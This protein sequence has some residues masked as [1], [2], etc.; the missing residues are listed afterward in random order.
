M[1]NSGVASYNVVL[2]GDG[3]VGKSALAI[4]LSQHEFVTEYN[5]VCGALPFLFLSFS[6]ALSLS[7]HHNLGNTQTI[8]DCFRHQMRVDDGNVLLEVMDTAGQ[9][10]YSSLRDQ[11][12]AKGQG[13]MV[14]YSVVA[15][16][17]FDSVV[18]Y[19]AHI[20]RAKQD[21]AFPLVLVGNKADLADARKVTTHEGQDLARTYK[22]PFFE[23]SGL[24]PC[25]HTPSPVAL[26]FFS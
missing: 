5:P 11:Y 24:P 1:Q 14:V 21:S 3:G 12:Y 15:R 8:E 7:L 9:E 23:T 26:F 16:A 20:Q 4:M 6:R 22:C 13:F 2:L 17:T 25:T 19:Q 18:D 10:E